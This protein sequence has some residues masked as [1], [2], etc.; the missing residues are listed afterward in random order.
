MNALATFLS[1]GASLGLFITA[2]CRW[3][4]APLPLH[5]PE[6]GLIVGS[7]A[8]FGGLIASVLAMVFAA[9]ALRRSKSRRSSGFVLGVSCLLLVGFAIVFIV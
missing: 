4:F 1:F 7:L 2:D 3:G 6:A 5:G 8:F 9:L